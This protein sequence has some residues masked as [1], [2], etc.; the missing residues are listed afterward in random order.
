MRRDA[1]LTDETDHLML[2]RMDSDQIDS[3]VKDWSLIKVIFSVNVLLLWALFSHDSPPIETGVFENDN[4]ASIERIQHPP[5][6][7][8]EDVTMWMD[9]SAGFFFY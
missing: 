2:E 8:E 7:I 3:G 6:Y 4:T 9:S 5:A 1:T